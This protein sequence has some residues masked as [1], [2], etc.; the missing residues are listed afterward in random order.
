MRDLIEI[1]NESEMVCEAFKEKHIYQ[2]W[3]TLRDKGMKWSD[4]FSD[5]NAF[6]WSEIDKNDVEIVDIDDIEDEF[7]KIRRLKAG[8]DTKKYIVFGFKNEELVCIFHPW[9]T[10]ITIIYDDSTERFVM[11]STGRDYKSQKEQFSILA[12][13]DYLVKVYID[14]H[15]INDLRDERRNAKNGMWELTDTDRKSHHLSKGVLG[16]DPGGRSDYVGW[17]TYYGRCK[18]LAEAAVNKWK[19]IVA[20][21][22][23]A[24][25]QDTK[26]VDDA[27]QG[28]MSRLTK[29]TSNIMKDPAKYNI[30]G[31]YT[32]DSI[33]KMIYDQRRH[34]GGRSYTTDD[35]IGKDGL[36]L[37][38]SKY[39][40]TV[41]DLRNT[42]SGYRNPSSL[43]KDRDKYKE[44][45][46]NLC[47]KLDEIFKKY[48]A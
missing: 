25:T 40:G 16:K 18:A 23:F 20:D 43:L 2:A 7:A 35:Y 37:L 9:D 13:C 24:Q 26:E 32:F 14:A 46:L 47:K 10:T 21:R 8:K 41:V 44:I 36:L 28:I 38:Y 42:K 11:D 39:C 15:F 48:D 4:I 31:S 30:S 34:N 5:G 19:S 17:D 12:E 1:V 6:C 22:K 45:V 29:V 27:V 33:M 3:K